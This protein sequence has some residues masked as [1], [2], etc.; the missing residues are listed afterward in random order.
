MK[1]KQ[2]LK[3]RFLGALSCVTGSSTLIEFTSQNTK[4]RYLVDLGLVQDDPTQT[5][6]IEISKI[7]NT[8]DGIFIT[9]AHADHIGRLPIALEAGFNG[10]I[11]LTKAT[12][13]LSRIM[14][15]D[16]F[17]IQKIDINKKTELLKSFKDKTMIFDEK[18]NFVFGKT[19]FPLYND[20]QF[21]VFR[22]SHILGAC[23]YTFRWNENI[24]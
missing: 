14:L 20:F 24:S 11:Y 5:P 4:K 16:Q 13:E 12:F 1:E 8:L 2:Q 15:A 3:I 6:D 7:A 9:H 10:K 19:C 18:E 17:N 23:S 21:M 22:S